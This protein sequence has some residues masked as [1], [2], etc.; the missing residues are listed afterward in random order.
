MDATVRDFCDKIIA[1][2]HADAC[3]GE[4]DTAMRLP[5]NHRDDWMFI[6]ACLKELTE[7]KKKAYYDNLRKM[8]VVLCDD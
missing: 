7:R 4:D 5:P 6:N 3:A 2:R 8:M 1:K